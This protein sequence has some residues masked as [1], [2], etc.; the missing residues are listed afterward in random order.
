MKFLPTLSLAMAACSALCAAAGQAPVA[1]LSS[2]EVSDHEGKGITATISVSLPQSSAKIVGMKA[3]NVVLH[4]SRRENVP[5]EVF[6]YDN[7]HL[8][9]HVELSFPPSGGNSVT[10]TGTL[11]LSVCEKAEEYV[12]EPLN[13]QNLPPMVELAGIKFRVFKNPESQLSS[14]DNSREKIIL[15]LEAKNGDIAS[16]SDGIEC[17]VADGEALLPIG[18]VCDSEKF[19]YDWSLPKNAQQVF[20]RCKSYTVSRTITLPLNM[21]FGICGELAP[22]KN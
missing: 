18:R 7:R 3:E 6:C 10:V 13:L 4:N 22:A 12:T 15:A 8:H 16:L 2:L 21:R 17:V 19:R 9:P 11:V 5:V 14:L 1:R 20:F